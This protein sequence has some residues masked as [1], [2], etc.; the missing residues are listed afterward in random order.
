MA[1]LL[2]QG[3]RMDGVANVSSALSPST[4]G[5]SCVLNVTNFVIRNRFLS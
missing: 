4:P 1:G 2:A 5:P 3:W